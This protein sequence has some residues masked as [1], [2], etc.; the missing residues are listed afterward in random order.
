MYEPTV[1]DE[2]LRVDASG[3]RWLRT[4]PGGGFEA[5]DAAFNL[6]VP[7]GFERTDL[8]AYVGERLASAG[9]DDSGDELV[10]PALLT[11]VS[12]DHARG[13]RAGD[14]VAFAT[15]GL[16]NPAALPVETTGEPARSGVALGANDAERPRWDGTVNLLV[17]T[18]R[19][20]S[21]GALAELLGTVV[22]AKAATLLQAAG[23]PGTTSDAVAVATDP[24]GES[25]AFCG[26]ATPVGDAA[27]ACVREAVLASLASRYPDG[28]F[29]NG[30]TDAEHGTATTRRADVFEL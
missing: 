19:S 14:V 7:K 6:T 2:V 12:M 23:V 3:A 26:S 30:P 9:F 20:L 13:A 25:A 5:A 27:R 28:G 22:E 4:G 1:R 17:G 11:G 15:A 29:P 16:S 21:E 8:D 18:T 10:G 24:D